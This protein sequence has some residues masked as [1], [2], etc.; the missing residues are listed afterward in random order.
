MALKIFSGVIVTL[1]RLQKK[2]PL[3]F[4][5][6]HR[7]F[8]ITVNVI[9]AKNVFSNSSRTNSAPQTTVNV[10]YRRCPWM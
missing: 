9:S 4:L 5:H 6:N 10:T 1:Y 7:G 8:Q 2:E 3:M